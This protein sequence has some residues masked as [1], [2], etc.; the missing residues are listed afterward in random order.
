MAPANSTSTLS[1]SSSRRVN[2]WNFEVVEL[3][4][5]GDQLE[6]PPRDPASLV[7]LFHG[8]LRA[9]HLR[10]GEKRDL[11]GLIFEQSDLDRRFVGGVRGG[12]S[13]KRPIQSATHKA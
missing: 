13:R 12:K 2:S 11:A 9:A 1:L 8:E 7:D 4:I 10:Q 5:V 6:L 3:R